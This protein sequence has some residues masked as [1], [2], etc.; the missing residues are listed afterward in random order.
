MTRANNTIVIPARREAAGPESIPRGAAEHGFGFG[1]SGR[2]G[3][4]EE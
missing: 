1:P 2:P 4:T 3:M